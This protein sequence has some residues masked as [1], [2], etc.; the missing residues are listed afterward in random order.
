MTP[1]K[2]LQAPEAAPRYGP[3][4]AQPGK[5]DPHKPYLEDRL[6][7]GVCNAEVLLGEI[8]QELVLARWEMD[9]FSNAHRP[10]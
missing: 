8:R 5:L 1:R 10:F 7:A 9:Q 6:K 4:A 3:R 2:Y